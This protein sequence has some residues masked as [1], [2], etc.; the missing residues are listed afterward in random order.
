MITDPDETKTHI[1]VYFRDLYQARLGTPEY[2][3]WTTH[4]SDTVKKITEP[5]AINTPGQGNE[6]ITEL[7][8]KKAIKNLKKKKEPR[9][10]RNPEWSLHRKQQKVRDILLK[11]INNIHSTEEIPPSWLQ[12]EIITLYKGKGK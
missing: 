8:I 5:R 11:N 12:G 10:W 4:I 6:T 9:A 2:E 3:T 1:E 7:E